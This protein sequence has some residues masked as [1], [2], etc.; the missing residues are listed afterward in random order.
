MFIDY[1]NPDEISNCRSVAIGALTANL[2]AVVA[3]TLV[4]KTAVTATLNQSMIYFAASLPL[5]VHSASSLDRVWYTV[6]AGK[7]MPGTLLKGFLTFS[8]IMALAA[9]TLGYTY[10]FFY[11]SNNA[12]YAYL[13]ASVW[14]LALSLWISRKVRAN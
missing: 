14:G 6:T 11:Y 1:K 10:L 5:L 12:V 8:Y 2:A 9:T 4:E 7:N 3:I 13:V